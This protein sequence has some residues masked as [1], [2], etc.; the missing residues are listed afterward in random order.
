MVFSLTEKQETMGNIIA[1][2]LFTW[3]FGIFMK[4]F[5]GIFISPKEGSS[6]DSGNILF[7]WFGKLWT[8]AWGTGVKV[9]TFCLSSSWKLLKWIGVYIGRLLWNQ[10]GEDTRFGTARF[11][12]KKEINRLLRRQNKGISVD[13]S[14]R[15]RLTEEAS[16]S[17]ALITASSGRGK[18]SSYVVNNI[19]ILGKEKQSIVCSDPSGELYN[20]TSGY[21]KKQG[22]DIKVLDITNIEYSMHYNPIVH[23]KTNQEVAAFASM[24]I[25]S[26]Y[27]NDKTEGGTFWNNGA[28]T[29]VEIFTNL[30]RYGYDPR[31]QNIPNVYYLISNFGMDGSRLAPLFTQSSIPRELFLEYQSFC[32]QP[33][34]VMLSMVSTARMALKVLQPL[35]PIMT[36]DTLDFRT[37]RSRPTMLYIKCRESALSSYSFIFNIF[38]SQLFDF[39]MEGLSKKQKS[40]YVLLD[41]AGNLGTMGADF[42]TTLTTLRKY[43]VSVSLILQNLNQF[44]HTFGEAQATTIISNTASKIFFPGMDIESAEKIEKLLGNQTI[45][46]IDIRNQIKSEPYRRPLYYAD[47][48]RRLKPQT[49]LLFY[50]NERPIQLS[51]L[52]YYKSKKFLRMTKKKPVKFLQNKLDKVE[53]IP[54]PPIVQAYPN[55]NSQN[56][57]Q[58]PPFNI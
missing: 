41:E 32:N 38:Y 3:V 48:I 44:V 56:N 12:T 5:I 9:V 37:T 57:K 33:E 1:L 50:S 27:G 14:E 36:K 6:A 30:L 49:G 13:G 55:G 10:R 7:S 15:H 42:S 25:T 20:L 43:R 23:L 46:D 45:T 51:F 8:L 18:T 39:F 47:E 28:I 31:F 4:T 22:Y 16:F 52:P 29:L 40:V 53:Y 24:L 11:A 17:H 26:M 34:K 35:F 54:I 21:L 19:L 58:Y 2:F